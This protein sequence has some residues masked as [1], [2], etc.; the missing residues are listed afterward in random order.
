FIPFVGVDYFLSST[1]LN[2]ITFNVALEENY[3]RVRRLHLAERI[4][5]GVEP[6]RLAYFIYDFPALSQTFVLNELR[7][8]VEKG[9]DVNVYYAVKPEA[10][11]PLD[12]DI[13]AFQVASHAELAEL[14][15]QHGRTICHSHFAYPGVTLFVQP[16]C[17]AAEVL[18]T[19]M[20][21]AVD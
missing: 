13:Q 10:E 3:Q 19:F 6:I 1:Q 16:A 17:E 11:A 21:H 14:L 20:P 12:F 7:W 5:Y 8:L 2:N 4:R 18:Y 15:V 9:V